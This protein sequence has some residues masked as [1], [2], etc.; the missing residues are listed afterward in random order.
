MGTTIQETID[1]LGSHRGK[2]VGVSGES[3]VPPVQYEAFFRELPE[4]VER[5]TVLDRDKEAGG[6][7]RAVV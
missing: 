3:S 1:Y 6:C 7:G 4:T 5:I 2:K